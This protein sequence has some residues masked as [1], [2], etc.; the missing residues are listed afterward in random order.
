MNRANV[1][2]EVLPAMKA[3]AAALDF[4][5]VKTLVSLIL[6]VASGYDWDPPPPAFL[7]EV[8]YRNGQIC[9]CA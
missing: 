5:Y 2:F 4:A 8:G 1:S 6:P 3:L 7:D 9:A